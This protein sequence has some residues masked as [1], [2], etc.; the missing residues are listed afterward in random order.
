MVIILLTEMVDGSA[1]TVQILSGADERWA[2]EEEQTLWEFIR[3]T[4]KK[5]ETTNVEIFIPKY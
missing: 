1:H 4:M 3:S 2:R 5:S